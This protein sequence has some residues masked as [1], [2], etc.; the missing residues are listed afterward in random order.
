MWI[1][2]DN[3]GGWTAYPLW[4]FDLEDD[5]SGT[6]NSARIG[7]TAAVPELRMTSGRDHY[8]EATTAEAAQ[9]GSFTLTVTL[10][11]AGSNAHSSP[12]ECSTTLND[13]DEDMS[14]RVTR[15]GTW[16]E[17][18]N[19]FSQLNTHTRLRAM[20]NKY[21]YHVR[22]RSLVS[23]DLNGDND[24]SFLRTRNE[25]SP[26]HH[27]TSWG[28][29]RSPPG[30]STPAGPMAVRRIQ[31]AGGYSV[32]A[33]K[34]LN[35]LPGRDYTISVDIAPIRASS[36]GCQT[37]LGSLDGNNGSWTRSGSCSA[38]TCP[39]SSDHVSGGY[40]HEVHVHPRPSRFALTPPSARPSHP[41][42]G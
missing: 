40:A 17:T 18:C 24:N 28:Y 2:R 9:A 35:G 21:S 27:G 33:G 7:G 41:A 22:E 3:F 31:D 38:A 42:C 13:G 4:V 10:S 25:P 12:P 36:S 20:E 16:T 11:N 30:S 15:S 19:S 23:I 29:W 26:A 8:V 5:N 34:Y 6:G 1:P 39:S 37:S 14:G 32:G